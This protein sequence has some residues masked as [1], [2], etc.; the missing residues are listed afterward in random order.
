MI[1]E[2]NL[3]LWG[4]MPEFLM[5]RPIEVG[6]RLKPADARRLRKLLSA[7]KTSVRVVK[8]A[9]ALQRFHQGWGSPRV[10]EAVGVTPE[11]ARRIAHRYL[12]CGLEDALY[13]RP[14]KGHDP[15][16]DAKQSSRLIAMVCSDPPAGRERWTLS[17]IQAEA[18]RRGLAP[19]IG[20]ET[21]R[22]LL[23]R[24]DLKPWRKKNVVRTPVGRRVYQSDGGSA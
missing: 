13:E 20:V 5:A 22:L 9:Q 16:L 24:H 4:F 11:T 7:G 6:L 17:L 3:L 1:T 14:R 15:I 18:V 19:T 8:R 21:I 23:H 2:M 10:A 12:E